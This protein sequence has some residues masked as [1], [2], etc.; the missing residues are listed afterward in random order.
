MTDD[1]LAHVVVTGTSSGLGL[2]LAEKLL[3]AQYR[4]TGIA[5][6][7]P[8]RDLSGDYR[9]V[10]A[11]LGDLAGL[12]GLAR[13]IVRVGGVPYGLVNNAAR[14]SDGVLPLMT[15]RAVRETLELD[16]L[17][18]ILL[19]KHLV[20]HMISAGTGRVVT[21]SSIA[22]SSGM[23]GLSVYGAAKA[24]L[25]GFTRALARDVGRRG[26]TVNAV[27]PGF[28]DTDMTAEVSERN[29]ER[30]RSRSAL[31]RSAEVDEVCGAV[32]YLLSPAASGIT[33]HV[34]TVDAGAT[35]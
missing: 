1:T 6:R 4:V 21:V 7:S 26:V 29:L 23:R 24:G 9:H 33:G 14:G 35:A 22:A 32:V 27:A 16:L 34:L 18:P 30:I 2:A 19:T 15:D 17:S 5:R 20:K 31:G 10:T 13:D 8:Q 3:A 11:D 28:L 25:E 12:P